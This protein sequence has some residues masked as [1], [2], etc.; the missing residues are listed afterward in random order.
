M[1]SKRRLLLSPQAESDLADILQ[2]T[3]ETW[4]DQQMQ[5]YAELLDDSLRLLADNPM[6]GFTRPNVS[7]DHRFL[8]AGEHLI[9]YRVSA[10]SVEV[11][12]IVHG[13]MDIKSQI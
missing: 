5:K 9:A 6:V 12:R 3:F 4:G 1:S 10:E 11:S 7:A 13:R 8:P 2:Y